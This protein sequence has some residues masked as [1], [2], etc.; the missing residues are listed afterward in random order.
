MYQQLPAIQFSFHTAMWLSFRKSSKLFFSTEIWQLCQLSFQRKISNLS[1]S[2]VDHAI[3][4]LI[5]N[6]KTVRHWMTI[7][8]TGS[9]ASGCWHI[10]QG[11]PVS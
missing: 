7:L 4:V 9:G 2:M 3:H 8:T 11:T 6:N 10:I 1:N 5:I